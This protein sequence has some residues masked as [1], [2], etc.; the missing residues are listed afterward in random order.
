[1]SDLDTTF[2][3]GDG[4]ARYRAH[5]KVVVYSY[6]TSAPFYLSDDVY[7]C[8]TS[9][10]VKGTGQLNISV[11]PRK[12]YMNYIFP[13][14]YI[15]V[16]FDK[17]DGNGWVR[18]F[19]GMVDKVEET[20]EVDAASGTPRTY[21]QVIAS[22]FGKAVDRLTVIFNPYLLNRPELDGSLVGVN[23]VG[24]L[25]NTV[26]GFRANGSPPDVVVDLLTLMFGNKTQFLLPDSLSPRLSAD[27]RA[28]RFEDLYNRTSPDVRARLA[29]PAQLQEILETVRTQVTSLRDQALAAEPGERAALL[30]RATGLTQ[31]NFGAPQNN[32]ED[33]A[34]LE[35]I[36][37]STMFAQQLFPESVEQRF[38]EDR[39]RQVFNAIAANTGAMSWLDIVDITTYVERSAI[40]GYLPFTAVNQD[41]GGLMSILRGFSNE[42]VVEMFFDLRPYTNTGGLDGDSYS[43]ETD[44]TGEN[45]A[46]PAGI[47]GVRYLP[48]LVMREY[49]FSTIPFV[50]V[51]DRGADTF[52]TVTSDNRFHFGAI[53]S[54]NPNVPGRHTVKMPAINPLDIREGVSTRRATKHIDVV[55]LRDTEIRSTK[56][57]R[58]DTD[59]MNYFETSTTG[60]AQQSL[61]FLVSSI[62]PIVSPIQIL[63]HGARRRAITSR[64]GSVAAGAVAASV[65]A[66]APTTPTG[67]AVS[68]KSSA[69]ASTEAAPTTSPSVFAGV[70]AVWPVVA[71]NKTV[72][73]PWGYRS[74]QITENSKDVGPNGLRYVLNDKI[75][76]F[77]NGVDIVD[78]RRRGAPRV[79]GRTEFDNPQVVAV[80]DGEVVVVAKNGFLQNYGNTVIIRHKN[81]AF[82]TLYAH[83]DSFDPELIRRFQYNEN[84]RSSN[85]A[86][87]V[88]ISG[89]RGTATP[90]TITKGTLIGRVGGTE[91]PLSGMNPH[92]HFEVIVPTN[93]KF[94]PSK[95]P[96]GIPSLPR[97]ID[98]TPS[99]SRGAPPVGTPYSYSYVPTG[100]PAGTAPVTGTFT[101]F[102]PRSVD[103]AIFFAQTGVT[104]PLP[105]S[106]GADITGDADESTDGIEATIVST[107]DANATDSSGVAQAPTA[108]GSAPVTVN[109]SPE[110]R[111]QVTRWTLLQ[112][113]WYQHNLEYLSGTITLRPAPE[114]RVGYRLDLVDRN[115]SFYVESVSHSWTYGNSM[116][117]VLQVTRGQP[118]NPFPVYVLPASTVVVDEVQKQRGVNS[119]LIRYFIVPDPL[120]VRRSYAIRAANDEN[121]ITDE[122]VAR[123]SSLTNIIDTADKI[124]D[125]AV[126]YPSTDS[127]F[128]PVD[129]DLNVDLD[130]SNEAQGDRPEIANPA[131]TTTPTGDT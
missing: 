36:L 119:R 74:K 88:S 50:E 12:N 102:S 113:H 56:F 110:I 15:N 97:A 1:M 94:Y 100:A 83:L 29:D 24:G 60:V 77:H 81:G 58:S 51:K 86:R 101:P 40:D 23:R 2:A 63:R 105:N 35:A 53:F 17:G 125:E 98:T 131:Q 112:D 129:L 76:R 95:D 122:Y 114:I 128:D 52:R 28:R 118:N 57:S 87:G 3:V 127:S 99:S 31:T 43:R 49:P 45:L 66:T 78:S 19:F 4:L 14:D 117:T 115:L 25:L 104:A 67:E 116:S 7:A 75:W 90:L 38:V 13:N 108:N 46:H 89:V 55:T 124:G 80:A 8:S 123:L 42:P 109:D 30:A 10:T 32:V 44:D 34:R 26:A 6:Q 39:A 5:I 107:P 111:S 130:L 18:T 47:A 27:F 92:L 64:Y 48:A 73:S 61:P 121:R 84:V 21:Y 106:D 11:L 82:Y 70:T 71:P 120:A 126:V 20:Y 68:T 65:A 62:V 85:V 41:Q 9:K 79:N 22:D 69:P 72:T 91:L 96:A 54:R 37:F 59:H 103:P 33:P 16:Y 93:G